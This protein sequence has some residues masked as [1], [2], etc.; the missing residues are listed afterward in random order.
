MFWKQISG[1]FGS[2]LHGVL[3]WG[4]LG[5]ASRGCVYCLSMFVQTLLLPRIDYV[6]E[7]LRRE[8]L[9][10]PGESAIVSTV[11]GVAASFETVTRSP[12][13]ASSERLVQL[14]EF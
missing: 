14:L 12:A 2:G 4:K 6:V 10:P 11:T 9:L 13:K 5:F 7:Y 8:C 1:P 3:L